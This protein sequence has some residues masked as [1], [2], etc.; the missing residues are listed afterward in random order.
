MRKTK[1]GEIPADIFA[2]LTCEPNAEVGRVHAKAMPVILTTTAVD[3]RY[4]DWGQVRGFLQHWQTGVAQERGVGR[5]EE[6][7]RSTERIRRTLG[8]TR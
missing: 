1:E 4:D 5:H 2:L 3:P 7:E 8:E 6:G